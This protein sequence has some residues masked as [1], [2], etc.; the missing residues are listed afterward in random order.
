M[1]LVLLASALS[2]LPERVALE[3]IPMAE[4]AA[5]YRV[6]AGRCEKDGRPL[7]VRLE[8]GGAPVE[9]AG[10]ITAEWKLPCV[11]EQM[12][13]PLPPGMRS[14]WIG[15]SGAQDDSASSVW[16]GQVA[17]APKLSGV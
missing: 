13:A 9:G 3:S 16:I 10:T 17:L 14:A 12:D 11:F 8:N 2:A 5:V 7:E 15:M 1:I 6:S 4:N